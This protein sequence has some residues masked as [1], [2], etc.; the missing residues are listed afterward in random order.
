MRTA[1]TP[2]MR[3]CLKAIERLTEEEVPPSYDVLVERLGYASKG[4]LHALLTRMKERGYVDWDY[5]KAHTLRVV[6]HGGTY[7]AIPTSRLLQMRARI[8]AELVSRS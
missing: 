1:L 2:A 5:G 7:S 4:S 8:D 6:P 3:D